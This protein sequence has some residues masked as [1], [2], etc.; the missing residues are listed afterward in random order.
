MNNNTHIRGKIIKDF[1]EWTAFS[2]TRS[3]CPIKSR[4]E[5]YPLIRKPNY[6]FLFEGNQ[7]ICEDE[8][9]KWHEESTYE[10]IKAKD[11]LPIGWAVKLINIYLKTTVYIGGLGRQDLIK[12]IHPP[13]DNGLWS[14]IYSQFKDDEEIIKMTHCVSRIK[15]I[16]TYDKYKKI[17]DGCKLVA[18]NLNC[19]L[20]EV[21]TLWQ[22]TLI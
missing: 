13:I 9:N 7:K 5:V 11:I 2:A 12:Y 8:F 3:G 6:N 14:G 16:N 21:E 17:I 15:D 1:A 20:I 4:E 19:L 10:I 22:G 18:K